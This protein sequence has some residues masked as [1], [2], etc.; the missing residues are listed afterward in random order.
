MCIRDSIGKKHCVLFA[1]SVVGCVFGIACCLLWLCVVFFAVLVCVCAVCVV[2][3]V[4]LL[5]LVLL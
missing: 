3:C 2:V 5:W 1:V 4:V